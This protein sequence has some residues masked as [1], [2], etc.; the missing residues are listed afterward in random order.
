MTVEREKIF[1]GNFVKF[2]VSLIQLTSDCGS[3]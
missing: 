2:Y 3:K 1:G